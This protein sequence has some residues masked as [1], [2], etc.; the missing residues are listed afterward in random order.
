LGYRRVCGLP[1]PLHGILQIK[2]KFKNRGEHHTVKKN[3][4]LLILSM[5][6]KQKKNY[7]N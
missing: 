2:N 1:T 3:K 4:E 6:T 7:I 5:K